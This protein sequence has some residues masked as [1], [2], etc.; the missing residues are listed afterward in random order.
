MDDSVD[1]RRG[2]RRR[3]DDRVLVC[4]PA[5][6]TGDHA[7]EIRARGREHGFAVRETQSPG[8]ARRLA[9][10]AAVDGSSLIAVAGG[11][12]TVNEAVHGLL[13]A[14]ALEEVDLA[15]IPT[16]TANLFA[17]QFGLRDV[18]R[19][20]DALDAGSKER[21]DV[22][23]ADCRPFVNTCLVGLSAEANT[24]T[25]DALKRRLGPF[26]Y[27]LTT[28]RHLSEYD[29][30]PL[31]VTADGD[32]AADETGETWQGDALLVLVGNA[33][34]FPSLTDRG[35][36]SATDGLLEVTIVEE[37]GRFEGL[38]GFGR[39]SLSR[40]LDRESSPITRFETPSLTIRACDGEVPPVSLDGESVS[41][42]EL[43][44]RVR[45]RC[46]SLYVDA[47]R[48]LW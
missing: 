37:N 22:G 47:K 41:A 25:P 23:L 44:L 3:S 8:D 13:E 42:T 35:D 39:E 33:F 16:G 34:R 1:E 4:N 2:G 14:N 10:E 27:V 17:R 46:L 7:G 9:R 19:A 26:A 24:A 15:V 5:S 45:E 21:I 28:L 11:D 48:S 43:E 31:E 36:R 29:G 38:D 12:G 32:A 18:D 30:L 6:G 40:L 20:F